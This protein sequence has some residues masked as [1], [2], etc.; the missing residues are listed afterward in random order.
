MTALVV[1]FAGALAASPSARRVALR[2][3]LV[4]M[5]EAR[6]VHLEP[7]P[8]LG[9][10]AI[11]VGFVLAVVSASLVGDLGVSSEI[12]AI[13]A[14]GLL[15][16]AAGL[17]DDARALPLQFKLTVEV[18]IAAGLYAAGVRTH[19]FEVGGLDF[20]LTI[21]WIVG[22]T[23]AVNLMDNMDGLTAGISAIAALYLFALGAEAGQACLRRWDWSFASRTSRRSRSSSRSRSSPCQSSTR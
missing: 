14:G 17:L 5:P 9:G 8:Y 19:L 12:W 23:N 18:A 3:S 6:K 16:S 1:S 4:D 13:L 7:V 2:L 11:V 22:I 20:I 15:I 21:G 10:T